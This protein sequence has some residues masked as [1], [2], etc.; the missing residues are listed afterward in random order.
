M[1]A[2]G[3]PR[4][5]P[6]DVSVRAAIADSLLKGH[7]YGTAAELAGVGRSTVFR[8]LAQGKRDEEAEIES[9]YR[10]FRDSLARS[11]ETATST[12]EAKLFEIAKEGKRPDIT[13]AVVRVRA[14]EWRES[15]VIEHE[16][17]EDDA[18]NDRTR[19]EI[20]AE[21]RELAAIS[22]VGLADPEPGSGGAAAAAGSTAPAR[23]GR[24][25]RKPVEVQ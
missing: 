22:G 6:E 13:L 10:D 17:A 3:R 20:V 2:P 24:R 15:F 5:K 25:S 12:L 9:P 4:P 21:I 1:S 16:E 7:G 8:W 11:Y 18:G 23:R 19:E 14:P